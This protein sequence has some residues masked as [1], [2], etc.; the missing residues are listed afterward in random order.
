MISTEEVRKLLVDDL[1]PNR[2]GVVINHVGSG[3]VRSELVVKPW[4]LAPN[5]FL[6]AGAVIVLADASAGYG[7]V[8]HLPAGAVGFTTVELKSNHLGTAR[9]GTI[10]CVAKAMHLG[11]TT[12]VWDAIVTHRESGKTVALFRC[13]QMV[14]YAKSGAESIRQCGAPSKTHR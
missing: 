2:M 5:T 3:E 4:L 9:D 12:Q 7:C 11:R 13:T 6:H 8:A 10:E 1:L 14:L